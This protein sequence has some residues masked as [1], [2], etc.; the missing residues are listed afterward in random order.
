MLNLVMMEKLGFEEKV[1]CMRMNEELPTIEKQYLYCCYQSH[2]PL[3][4]RNGI[5]SVATSYYWAE[6]LM[7]RQIFQTPKF[8]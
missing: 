1:G 5:C 3:E 8:C 2:L 7:F 6:K 4:I